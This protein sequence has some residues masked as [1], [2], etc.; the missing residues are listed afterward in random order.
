MTTKTKNALVRPGEIEIGSVRLICDNGFSVDLKEIMGELTIN[1]DLYS[2]FIYGEV[3]I[4]DTLSLIKNAPII[5]GEESL[6]IEFNIPCTEPVKQIYRVYKVKDRS[7]L[8]R[9]S[10]EI[11]TLCF[12]S[13][14]LE[15]NNDIEITR[16][17]S[18]KYSEIAKILYSEYL[19]IP[20]VTPPM[21]VTE[22]A[23]Q[24]TFSTNRW[25][26][27]ETFNYMANRAISN[28]NQSEMGFLF[29][30]RLDS[31]NFVN[32]YDQFEQEPI[33]IY[34]RINRSLALP[35]NKYD[36]LIDQFNIEDFTII[37]TYDSIQ[38]RL[39]GGYDSTTTSYDITSKQVQESYH[40]Y[41]DD[42]SQT[43]SIEPFPLISDFRQNTDTTEQ[44]RKSRQIRI[45]DQ[46]ASYSF[47]GVEDNL[48]GTISEKTNEESDYRETGSSP[49][50]SISQLSA[51][52]IPMSSDIVSPFNSPSSEFAGNINDEI[53]GLVDTSGP[54]VSQRSMQVYVERGE[55][56]PDLEDYATEY[57]GFNIEF[58]TE[59]DIEGFPFTTYE[60]SPPPQKQK[61]LPKQKET[62]VGDDQTKQPKNNIPTTQQLP[63]RRRSQLKSLQGQ[64]IE[65]TVPG[66][67]RR[68]IGEIVRVEIPSYESRVKEDYLD[69][70][71]SGKYMISHIKHVIKKDDYKLVLE[72]SRNARSQKLPENNEIVKE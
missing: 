21:N 1:E 66:D 65:I 71:I 7:R 42:F 36:L 31:Y 57:N 51:D 63:L 17:F 23:N 45:L 38:N 10:T 41:T 61:E 44:P 58:R 22:S 34:R 37:N 12:A 9:D 2:P 55:I 53:K 30:R 43:R 3:T 47:D 72:I 28:S 15:K 67:S 69:T 29:F 49:E 24:I 26:P 60:I 19:S 32:I 4:V 62:S 11:F 56:R 14:E 5:G 16:T 48:Y 64:V 35:E 50:K 59:K 6:L 13:P 25:T 27:I 8:D 39:D 46:R 52:S 40:S 20:E 70:S 68:R 33:V 54:T 18:G